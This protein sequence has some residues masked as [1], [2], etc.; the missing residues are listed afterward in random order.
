MLQEKE[1]PVSLRDKP[2]NEFVIQRVFNAPRH[3]VWK[4]FSEA[5]RLAE[6][7][8]PAGF[9]LQ[10]SKLEFSPGGTFHYSMQ[11]PDGFVMWGKFVY[12]EIVEPKEIIFVLSFSDENGGIRRAPMSAKWPLEVVN[13]LSF[14]EQDGK[15]TLTLRST[16]INATAEEIKTFEAGFSSMQ[17]GFTGT[18]NQLE[19]YLS[20][21]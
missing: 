11:S 5:D 3:L 1:N 13:V 16:P 17:Q 19:E 9:K 6:W 15:T 18:F 4:A 7:W 14:E 10:V 20:K 8:G 12:L 21:L 2:A